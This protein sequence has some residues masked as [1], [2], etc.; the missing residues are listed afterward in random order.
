MSF[1]I[2][3]MSTRAVV[4]LMPGIVELAEEVL[5]LMKQVAA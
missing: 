4:S 3:A 5:D 2:S 1:P